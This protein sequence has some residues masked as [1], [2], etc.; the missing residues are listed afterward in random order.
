[1]K[2]LVGIACL[3]PLVAFSAED[4]SVPMS[5]AGKVRYRQG[6]NI[7]FGETVIQGQNRRPESAVVT[8]NVQQGGDGLI[9]LRENFLDRIS[10][11]YAESAE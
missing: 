3:L 7:D 8:G 10:V 5:G 2:V 6:K 1:M 9:R 11:D 4:S